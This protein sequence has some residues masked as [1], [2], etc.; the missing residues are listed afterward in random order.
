VLD[1]RVARVDPDMRIR[2][3]SPHPKDFGPDC[4]EAISA[5]DNICNHLHMPAQSGST[6]TLLRMRRGYSRASYDALI[7][8][9]QAALPHVV[10]S[11]DIIVGFC[12]ETEAEHEETLDLLRKMRYGLG[13]LFAY[14]RR[15]KTHAARN[16]VDDV[17]G[18][19]KARRLQEALQVFGLGVASRRQELCGSRQLVRAAT[20]LHDARCSSA[21][22]QAR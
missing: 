22:R 6:S 5:H 15:E 21:Y 12:G 2:F 16:Y 9:A 3:S 19:V 20:V 7:S 18:D 8:R 10:F 4:L 17:P 13:F 11:T 14:S 1:F